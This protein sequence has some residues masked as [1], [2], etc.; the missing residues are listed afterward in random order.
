[1]KFGIDGNLY[2]TVYGQSDVTLLGKDG[3]VLKRF[4]TT[5]SNPT[6]CAFGLP[7][8]NKLYVKEVEFGAVDVFDLENDCLPLYK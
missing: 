4:K 3:I 5:G 8:E 1:M 2:V 7:G 6:K